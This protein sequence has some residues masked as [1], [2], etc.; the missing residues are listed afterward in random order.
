[1]TKE[2]VIIMGYNA[3]GKSTIAQEY[4]SQ[5]YTQ[6]NRDTLGGDLS[7]VVKKT[8]AALSNGCDKAV[9]D[10]TYPSKDQRAE[11]IALGDRLDIPVKCI[12]LD[13]SFEDA[14]LNSCLRMLDKVGELLDTDGCSKSK[15]PN[16]IPPAALF[17]YRKKFE[18]PSKDEGFS[19]IEKLKFK[20]KNPADWVNEA[21]IIDYDQTVRESRGK[22]K[23]PINP[24]DVEILPN[25][26]G[27][28]AD[29]AKKMP[30][31]G[32]SNQSGIAKKKLTREQAI[33]CFE[34]TNKQLGVKIEE[35]LFCPHNIPPVKCYC[36]KPH[37]GFG[38]YLMWKYKLDP[39]KCI[40]VGDQTSDK[41]FA[42]R[43]GFQ[44]A[45]QKDFFK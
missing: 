4:V 29:Y 28:L 14:Q 45:D 27:I 17:A 36:R 44:Y 3:A 25:R 34:E 7:S 12:H 37:P 35:Y 43:C 24:E 8:E 2:I 20:R 10:N 9:L 11:V 22:E 38:A 30:I 33:A 39:S 42:S 40:F 18:K 5:G 19:E 13:T 16:V 23:Y 41:T 1:M 32:V 26:K 15:D 21:L 31:F 6:F